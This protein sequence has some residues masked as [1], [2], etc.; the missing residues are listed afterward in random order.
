MTIVTINE[1]NWSKNVK[2]DLK[3]KWAI[4]KPGFFPGLSSYQSKDILAK[5]GIHFLLQTGVTE[6]KSIILY[7]GKAILITL[8]LLT[9]DLF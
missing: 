7:S 5:L 1:L 3:W 9:V 6:R 4:L 8:R 2:C